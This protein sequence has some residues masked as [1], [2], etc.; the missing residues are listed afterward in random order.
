MAPPVLPPNNT[1]QMLLAAL[2]SMGGGINP[3]LSYSAYPA[4][5][6]PTGVK[7][8]FDPEI[9]FASGLV[10]PDI[11]NQLTASQLAGLQSKYSSDIQSRLPYEASDMVFAPIANKYLGDDDLS[12]FMRGTFNVLNSGNK[13]L[14]QVLEDIQN[15][16]ITN[17]QGTKVNIPEVIKTNFAGVQQDL[18]DYVKLAEGRNSALS[19]F[20]YDQQGKLD[21]LGPAPTVQDA[22]MAMFKEMGVPQLGLLGDPNATYQF[23][24]SDFVDKERLGAAQGVLAQALQNQGMVRGQTGGAIQQGKLEQS[25][26]MKAI[27]E[28][29][30]KA[31]DA[32]VSGMQQGPTAGDKARAVFGSSIPFV[33][34]GLN[35]FNTLNNKQND[36]DT[37]MQGARDAAMKKERD[38]LM[39]ELLPTTDE[40]ARIKYSPEYRNALAQ[41]TR[42]RTGVSMENAYGRI[43]AETIARRLA[44]AGKT[45]FQQNMNDLLGYAIRTAR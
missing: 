10:T 32:A 2:S 42:A 8:A 36:L 9:L 7:S 35:L 6:S 43:V 41:S 15:G 33:G 16:Y 37:A 11:I 22:R 20:Q 4:R 1:L 24:P 26:A 30:R 5:V 28:A 38:R 21:T 3:N 18:T 29:V 23:N 45:P 25:Y 19:K 13:S 40:S 44:E 34:G 39:L 12:S 14:T 31:G 17:S 27:E